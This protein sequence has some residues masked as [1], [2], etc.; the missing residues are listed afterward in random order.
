MALE[1]RRTKKARVEGS[2][3]RSETTKRNGHSSIADSNQTMALESEVGKM[4]NEKQR[5]EE[6][7]LAVHER[8]VDLRREQWEEEKKSRYDSRT[9]QNAAGAN[10][11]AHSKA[12]EVRCACC[13]GLGSHHVLTF[14]DLLCLELLQ[15]SDCISEE[16]IECFLQELLRFAQL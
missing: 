5:L 2:E 8:E 14:N 6:R 16:G 7:R 4:W 12:Q 11:R 9:E 3:R 15:C 13:S 10:E 1:R